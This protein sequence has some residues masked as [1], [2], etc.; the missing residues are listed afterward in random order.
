MSGIRERVENLNA[1]LGDLVLKRFHD[2]Q[3]ATADT[4]ASVTT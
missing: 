3:D 4:L 2:P 1:P